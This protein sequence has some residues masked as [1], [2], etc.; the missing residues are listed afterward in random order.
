MVIVSANVKGF[1]ASSD[2]SVFDANLIDN[3]IP[4]CEAHYNVSARP[5]SARLA[6]GNAGPW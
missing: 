6:P 1:P 4:S 3:V 2:S 5:P